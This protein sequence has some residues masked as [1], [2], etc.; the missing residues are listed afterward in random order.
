M[1][2]LNVQVLYIVFG[3]MMVQLNRN[4]SPNFFYFF[5]Y[6]L[7][8]SL[9]KLLYYLQTRRGPYQNI[10]VLPIDW[11]SIAILLLASVPRWIKGEIHLDTM[12]SDI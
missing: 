2:S 9:N 12:A 4:M 8:Y 11:V 1:H 5:Q 7:C 6:K 3:L 10:T